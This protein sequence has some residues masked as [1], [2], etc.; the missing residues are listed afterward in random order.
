[1]RG[2]AQPVCSWVMWGAWGG[3]V[4]RGAVTFVSAAAE[5]DGMGA[6]PGLAKRTVAVRNMRAIGKKDV[7]LNA[8][9]PEIEVDPET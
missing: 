4:A 9:T 6:S 7:V 1:M 2:W 3:A 5:A 8:M